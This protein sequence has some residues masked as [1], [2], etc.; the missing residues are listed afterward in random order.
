MLLRISVKKKLKQDFSS[1]SLVHSPKI[2]WISLWPS[3]DGR[4]LSR[5]LLEAASTHFEKLRRYI[6]TLQ[7]QIWPP[8]PQNPIGTYKKAQLKYITVSEQVT[9]NVI[10]KYQKTLQ[11]A[12]K[13]ILWRN[14]SP[15]G[16]A[17]GA[18]CLSR[19]LPETTFTQF[20]NL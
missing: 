8:L 19:P 18:R 14:D 9:T 1:K 10:N 15:K 4:C 16:A 5:P 17:L 13:M 3:L 7:S 6:I 2:L 12:P 20:G 11:H